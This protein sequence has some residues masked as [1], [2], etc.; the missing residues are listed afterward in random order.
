MTEEEL[1]RMAKLEEQME[2]MMEIMTTMVKGKAK[3]GE[4]SSTL[5]NPI[6]F[7]GDTGVYCE[8]LPLQAPGVAIQIPRVNELPTN[9]ELR[10]VDKG[11]SIIDEEAH[12]FSLIEERLKAIER[13][14]T[15]G[16]I[17]SSKL[18][19]PLSTK[20]VIARKKK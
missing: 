17:E 6:P 19:N 15:F 5:D 10:E 2:M 18:D 1:A 9:E 11:K 12:K 14:D 20:R 3:L 13:L 4:G 16:S 7:L 8:D